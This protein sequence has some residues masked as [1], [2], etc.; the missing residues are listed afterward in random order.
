MSS[1]LGNALAVIGLI[2]EF[3]SVFLTIRKAFYGYEEELEDMVRHALEDERKKA[4][5]RR[6]EAYRVFLLLTVGMILQG[7]SLFV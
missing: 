2:L 5:Q 4:T 7:V 6:K 1:S 3:I